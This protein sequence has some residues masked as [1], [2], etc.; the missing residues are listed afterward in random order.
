LRSVGKE[1]Q[2][3]L[4]DDGIG[5]NPD[6]A[7]AKNTYGLAIMRDRI[8]NL[9]GEFLLE[10]KLGE[11]TKISFTVPANPSNSSPAK[12]FNNVAFVHAS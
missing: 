5:F 1:V 4:T 9:Q 12:D 6:E 8:K 10:S 7:A 11:G 2:G 3:S